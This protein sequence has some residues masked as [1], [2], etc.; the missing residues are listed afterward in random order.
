MAQRE[1]QHL[2]GLPIPAHWLKLP[3]GDHRAGA[4]V[5]GGRVGGGSTILWGGPRRGGVSVASAPA[6]PRK[7]GRGTPRPAVPDPAKDRA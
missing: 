7:S 3:A 4:P 1:G 6:A 2:G 5:R